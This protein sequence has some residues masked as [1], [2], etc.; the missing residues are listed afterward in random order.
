[1]KDE[2]QLLLDQ[3]KKGILTVSDFYSDEIGMYFYTDIVM[4]IIGA[5]MFLILFIISTWLLIRAAIKEDEGFFIV[6]AVVSG[7]LG[8]ISLFNLASN[9]NDL[10]LITYAPKIYIT[11][12]LIGFF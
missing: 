3:A 2:I 4:G 1:M 8:V 11:K 5:S 10:V 6:C 9:I 7:L 12:G